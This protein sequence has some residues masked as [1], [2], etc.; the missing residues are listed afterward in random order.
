MTTVKEV[1]LERPTTWPDLSLFVLAKNAATCL[2]RLISNVGPYIKEIVMVLNDTTDESLTVAKTMA[3]RHGLS[4][5][6]QEVTAATHPEF[7]I[8]DTASTY[9]AGFSLAG[10]VF[11]GPFVE[12]PILGDWAGVRNLM[13]QASSKP[14]K[15]FLDADDVI[16]DPEC[17]PGLLCRMEE[18]NIERADSTYQYVISDPEAPKIQYGESYRE[19]IVRNLPQIVWAR[20]IHENLVGTLRIAQIDGNLRVRDMR[21][22]RGFGVRIPGRNFKILYHECRSRNWQSDPRTLANLILETKPYIRDGVFDLL[23]PEAALALYLERSTWP[24]ER[25]WAKAMMGEMYEMRSLFGAAKHSYEDANTEYKNPKN[26]YRLSRVFYQMGLWQECIEA[27]HQADEHNKVLQTLDGGGDVLKQAGEIL[28]SA[29]YLELGNVKEARHHAEM[30][31]A[32]HP[33]SGVLQ[34]YLKQIVSQ[35]EKP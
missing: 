18:M 22:N 10:E 4:F 8:E 3:S 26:F 19:R 29:S 28:L 5:L 23:F 15:M 1:V 30:A 31:A 34:D 12:R 20:R 2:P 6:C 9:Q 7:Y 25:A 14:W 13:W 33:Q 11:Q 21:D 32:N 24:E 17:L 35:Q 27:Y 16:L